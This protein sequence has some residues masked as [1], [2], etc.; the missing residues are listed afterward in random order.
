MKHRFSKSF[1]NPALCG[2]C[3]RDS[4]SH[5][6]NAIC[7]ACSNVGNCEFYPSIASALATMLCDECLSKE[8]AAEE[9]RLAAIKINQT[10]V[11][12][13]SNTDI[14]N[15]ITETRTVIECR[16]EYYNAESQ[17]II[18]LK[19]QIFN[20]ESIPTIEAKRFK[21]AK[22]VQENIVSYQK[23]IFEINEKQTEVSNKLR[24]NIVYFNSVIDDLRVSEREELKIRDS[25]YNPNPVKPLNA[26]T[27]KVKLSKT[28]KTIDNY[29]KYHKISFDEAKKRLGV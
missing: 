19:T 29:A 24:A 27:P 28:D 9:L 20:D 26:V 18:E 10:K 21:L 8:K 15:T 11:N 2:V 6:D 1:I 23:A 7:D 17:A 5:T 16:Q 4:N 22:Q 12:G 14:T 25:S 3:K 13:V